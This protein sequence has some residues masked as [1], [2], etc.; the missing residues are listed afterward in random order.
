M[1]SVMCFAT[2]TMAGW[3]AHSLFSQYNQSRP[4]ENS[5]P[6]GKGGTVNKGSKSATKRRSP[7][8][9]RT[10]GSTTSWKPIGAA[11]DSDPEP[12]ET[13]AQDF[14]CKPCTVR[15]CLVGSPSRDHED[16]HCWD[17]QR[18]V[19]VDPPEYVMNDP[20]VREIR[21]RKAAS[22]NDKV[23]FY[24]PVPLFHTD[25][26]ETKLHMNRD[27]PGLAKRTHPLIKRSTC[28]LCVQSVSER[29]V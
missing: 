13:G 25:A 12:E 2:G 26:D 19:Y 16:D 14:R 9:A 1:W 23:V 10:I 3:F 17:P 22:S 7:S 8:P 28:K 11:S 20:P 18:G 5:N 6:K 24:P 27:C 15:P 4:K 29:I 21:S